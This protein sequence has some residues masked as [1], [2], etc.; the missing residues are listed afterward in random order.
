MGLFDKFK[1]HTKNEININRLISRLGF[2]KFGTAIELHHIYDAY[3]AVKEFIFKNVQTNID[4]QIE[5]KLIKKLD[6]EISNPEIYKKIHQFLLDNQYNTN[7]FYITLI[8]TTLVNTKELF[9]IEIEQPSNNELV[10]NLQ[11]FMS[12]NYLNENFNELQK[13]FDEELE[14]LDFTNYKDVFEDDSICKLKQYPKNIYIA[15]MD[16]LLK[17]YKGIKEPL[18]QFIE[19]NALEVKNFDD[20]MNDIKKSII[21]TGAL[22][23]YEIENN[24]TVL[25]NLDIN[26]IGDKLKNKIETYIKSITNN[27]ATV[28]N[29]HKKLTITFN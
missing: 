22:Q 15:D 29:S 7:E 16:K 9:K 12:L 27:K 11:L 20:L 13:L 14:K 24:F 1:N 25:K 18:N 6:E 17:K 21:G 2:T 19:E 23:R 28:E 4:K 26:K 8:Y 5:S 10:L 3:P